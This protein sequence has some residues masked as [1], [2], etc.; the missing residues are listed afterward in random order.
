M[1][2][3]RVCSKQILA[4]CSVR[5]LK[6][7]VFKSFSKH[8]PQLQSLDYPLKNKQILSVYECRFTQISNDIALHY[9]HESDKAT[10]IY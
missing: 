9:F 1:I 5:S 6:L 2:K 7:R 10:C 8:V 4:A 3:M